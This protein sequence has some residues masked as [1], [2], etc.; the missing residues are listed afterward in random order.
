LKTFKLRLLQEIF[1]A[2]GAKITFGLNSKKLFFLE[3]GKR[4]KFFLFAF[5]YLPGRDLM[6]QD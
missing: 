4:R 2:A 3:S 1:K 6:L 5:D